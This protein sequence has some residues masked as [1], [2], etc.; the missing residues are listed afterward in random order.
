MDLLARRELASKGAQCRS[1][2][3]HA[4]SVLFKRIGKP[5][6]D[7]FIG[8]PFAVHARRFLPDPLGNNESEEAEFHHSQR[9]SANLPGMS[10]IRLAARRLLQGHDRRAT[11]RCLDAWLVPTLPDLQADQL[12]G[13][14]ERTS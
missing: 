6:V 5:P 1:S 2:P 14:F 9:F 12:P 8:A 11:R 13:R 4:P 3:L 10:H 7:A